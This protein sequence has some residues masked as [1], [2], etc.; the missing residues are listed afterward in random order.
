ML[1]TAGAV[2]QAVQL[3][4]GMEAQMVGEARE[5]LLDGADEGV[6]RAYVIDDVDF[7]LGL[8]YPVQLAQQARLQSAKTVAT[9]PAEAVAMPEIEGKPSVT[10]VVMVVD[11]SLTVRKITSRLLEREGYQVL[12]A[13]D[14]VDA[15]Q[16]LKDNMP[17]VMLVDIEM[18]RMDGFD[19]TKNVRADPRLAKIPIV[20]IS[21]RTADKHRNQA[22]QLGVNAFLGKPYQEAELLQHIATFVGASG[23]GTRLH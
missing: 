6:A 20:I 3:E 23:P 2:H 4:V 15:L 22:A 12:T 11:D 10:P 8:A 5:A 21:S 18:P 1:D 16:Q 7:A 9:V 17:S 19:L 14:G 13:K